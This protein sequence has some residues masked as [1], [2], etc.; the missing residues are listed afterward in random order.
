M[1]VDEEIL[2]SA[3]GVQTVLLGQ[4]RGKAC[5]LRRM[6]LMAVKIATAR[7]A[8]LVLVWF[9]DYHAAVAVLI[10]KLLKKRTFIFIGGY[11]AVKYPKLGMGVYC[12]FL[13]GVC[14]RYALRHCDHIISN[15][16]AL[17]SSDNF[18]YDPKG[19]AEGIYRLIPD[20]PTLSSVIHNAISV[21]STPELPKERRNQIL[22]VGSTPR[23]NDFLN[24]G[25]DLLLEVARRRQ[26]LSFVFVGISREW[27]PELQRLYHIGSFSNLEIHPKLPQQDVIR[28]MQESRIYAQPSISEGM[29]NSLMEA[30]L[31]GCI[32][33]GSK[34]AGIPTVIADQGFVFERRTSQDLERA[35]DQALASKYD[36]LAIACSL[37]ARFGFEIRKEKLLGLLKCF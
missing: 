3:Y 11:D 20:L 7:K 15:H 4:D 21:K 16:Q 17:L 32:P 28:L 12:S 14:A 5:Y 33:V 10:S 6:F 8:R 29:P 26:D 1:R 23:F 18:Y 13:R 37:R 25:Y 34:V 27:L 31:M 35:L 19:H 9:A 2:G 22:T 30:M 36:P 24:K